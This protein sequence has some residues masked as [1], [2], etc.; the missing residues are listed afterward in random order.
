VH[1]RFQLK[2]DSYFLVSAHREENVDDPVRLKA[3]LESLYALVGAYGH[4]V[5]F[6]VHPRT[7]ERIDALGLPNPNELQIVKPLGFLDYVALQRGA[8]CVVSDSGTL[9][10][11]CAILGFP[12]V[13]I[14]DAHER[15]EGMD[16]GIVV[17]CGLK[18]DRVLQAVRTVRSQKAI[19]F[20]SPID[21]E[22]TNVSA[23]V[24]RIILSYTDY[25][26]RTTWFKR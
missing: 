20:R 7:R 21:Y 13:M 11:E 26:N 6:S 1:Q 24:V 2:E 3:L 8:F 12:A 25:V 19:G 10:E 22:P 18:S 14:R 23:K 5:L 9:T 17:M 15:P 16:E 4:P